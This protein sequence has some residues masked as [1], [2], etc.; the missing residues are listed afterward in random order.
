MNLPTIL[1]IVIGLFFIYFILSLLASEIL[2]LITTLMQWRAEHLKKSIEILLSGGIRTEEEEKVIALTNKL[3]SN[4]L[5]VNI[6]QQAKGY[7]ATIPRQITWI[8]GGAYRAVKKLLPGNQRKE[9]VF[10]KE[11]VSG[12]SYLD[13]E[14]FAT[15]LLESLHIPQLSQKLTE[16]KLDKF[17][18]EDL[19]SE[20]EKNWQSFKASIHGQEIVLE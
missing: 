16:E 9:C 19:M 4:P 11:R 12:P 15:S 2:E 13:S 7:F 1:E 3:Y 20:L 5:I 14:T 8:S 18:Q 10:G 6:N 17:V